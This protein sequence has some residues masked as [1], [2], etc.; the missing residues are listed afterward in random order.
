M[1]VESYYYY[2]IYIIGDIM[3][4]EDFVNIKYF[5]SNEIEATGANIK[6]VQYELIHSLDRLRVLIGKPIKL[7]FNGLTTGKHKAKEHPNGLACDIYI[8]DLSAEDAVKVSLMAASV[9]FRGIG[10]YWNGKM[11]SFHLDLRK[12]FTT[13]YGGKPLPGYSWNYKELTFKK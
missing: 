12:T 3:T 9:G 8:I 2:T 5:T 1:V 6:D 7:Q 10:I 13:W 11:W 4:R